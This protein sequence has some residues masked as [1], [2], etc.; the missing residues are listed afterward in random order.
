MGYTS[1][2]SEH[3][4]KTLDTGN[5]FSA[6]TA[7]LATTLNTL[8]TIEPVKMKV[9][10]FPK[11]TGV[12]GTKFI[13]WKNS[14]NG[15]LQSHQLAP[16]IHTDESS[17][18]SLFTAA[19]KVEKSMEHTAMM[20]VD[21]TGTT[22]SDHIAR[23]M[24]RQCTLVYGAIEQAVRG[25]PGA[26]VADSVRHQSTLKPK[27]FISGNAHYLY[28]SLLE[29][30]ESRS[31]AGLAT[32][33]SS[34]LDCS[35]QEH[36]SPSVIRTYYE[37]LDYVIRVNGGITGTDMSGNIV[38]LSG[39]PDT[40]KLIGL[41]KA[42]PP[43]LTTVKQLICSDT[44]ATYESALRTL[45]TAF[46]N[47]ITGT[48]HTIYG[49][50]VNAAR[51]STKPVYRSD[52]T[53]TGTRTQP[54][55][56]TGPGG[57][58]T[59][60]PDGHHTNRECRSRQN[61]HGS[62]HKPSTGTSGS[63]A[64]G[65]FPDSNDDDG[66][67]SNPES[68]IE[69]SGGDTDL[70]HCIIDTSAHKC[71]STRTT[72][73]TTTD[74]Q[75]PIDTTLFYFD[76]CCSTHI[77]GEQSIL[78]NV[79]SIGDTYM[80]CAN[81]KAFKVNVAGSFALTPQVHLSNVRQAPPGYANLISAAR[82]CD[83][84]AVFFGDTN[85]ISVYQ[86]SQIQRH[87]DTITI[88]GSPVV[89]FNRIGDVYGIERPVTMS[90]H[91]TP[92]TGTK[93]INQPFINE[94]SHSV[95][96]V[97]PPSVTHVY[98]APSG[99]TGAGLGLFANKAFKGPKAHKLSKPSHG[100]FITAYAGRLLVVGI[101]NFST[102]ETYLIKVTD[103]CYLDGSGT[104]F[105]ATGLGRFANRPVP[106]LKA[107]A[108]FSVN[109]SALTVSLVATRT[110][111][112]GDEILVNYGRA[113]K[114]DTGTKVITPPS[115]P[116]S[117]VRNI[118]H[119]VLDASTTIE[120]KEGVTI[121]STDTNTGTIT[122]PAMTCTS[123]HVLTP[124]QLLHHQLGHCS[125]Y[126]L[127]TVNQR[128]QLGLTSADITNAI[129]GTGT[130]CVGCAAGKDRRKKVST[131]TPL[132]YKAKVAMD[133]FNADICG[134]ITVTGTAGTKVRVP[135]IK[136]FTYALLFMDE[137][138]CYA[139]VSLLKLK[140][141]ATTALVT[142]IK[143]A[144]A[145]HGTTLKV[146]HSDGGGE[147]VNQEFIDFLRSNG[148]QFTTTTADHP[149]H[150][151][152]AE[153]FNG[154]TFATSRSMQYHCGA[155][156]WLWGYAVMYAV[157][158]HNHLPLRKLGGTA[159]IERYRGITRGIKHLHTYGC[160]AL[161]HTT[162]DGKIAPRI[163][164]AI[165]LG[166]NEDKDCH[167]LLNAGTGRIIH[168]RDVKFQ[169]GEFTQMALLTGNG[170]GRCTTHCDTISDNH[171]FV[172]IGYT[173]NDTPITTD[174]TDISGTTSAHAIEVTDNVTDNV[175]DIDSDSEQKH[176]NTS[177][178]SGTTHQPDSESVFDNI[179]S[180]ELDD[181]TDTS[182]G[183]AV[184]TRPPSSRIATLAANRVDPGDFDPEIKSIQD[185]YGSVTMAITDTSADLVV[186]GSDD[187]SEYIDN[188]GT[189]SSGVN[190]GIGIRTPRNMAEAKRFG[191]HWV[192]SALK[193]YQ[194]LVDRGVFKLVPLPHGVTAIPCKP[195]FKVKLD[196]HNSVKSFKTRI[197][198]QGF[199][200][201]AGT[202]Y[203]ETYAPTV[204]GATIKLMLSI[205]AAY[206]LE[207]HQL[208]FITAFLNASLDE[209]VYVKPPV[210]FPSAGTGMVWFLNKALYGLKQAPMVWNQALD[211]Y[212]RT[213]GY[214]PTKS[215]RCI[216]VK[217][218]AT[219]KPIILTVYV[220]DTLVFF[221]KS[222]QLQWYNDK[223]KINSKF[224]IEDLGTVN[225]ILNMKVVRD[226]IARTLLL[227][228]SAYVIQKLI[229]FKL[230]DCRP[231]PSPHTDPDTLVVPP[232][233][234]PSYQSLTFLDGTGRQLYQSMVGSLMYAAV[235]TRID[236]A[237]MVNCLAKYMISPTTKHSAA[238]IRVFKYLAGTT[239]LGLLFNCK[240]SYGTGTITGSGFT[241][242]CD[243][244]WAGDTIT[245]KSTT[246]YILMHNGTPLL[247]RSGRQP[248]VAGSS[249]ES[250][251][252]A[253]SELV[254]EHQWLC[255]LLGELFGTT[256][257]PTDIPIYTDSES[258][259]NI[260]NRDGSDGRTKHIAVRFHIIREA[261]Q[262]GTT[263]LEWVPTTDQL[264]DLLT[265]AVKPVSQFVSL[266]N[267]LL[268]SDTHVGQH[269]NTT[270]GTTMTVTGT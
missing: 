73:A 62:N 143:Q 76:S 106:P 240:H 237:F 12:D 233:T 176:S 22:V 68:D 193:E 2:K 239:D 253:M 234:D 38:S 71:H 137:A 243:A 10:A 5:T 201:V 31:T 218:S 142:V 161:V 194:S 248:V 6:I 228:Q 257:T 268:H 221:H 102:D 105:L 254:R 131:S 145:L 264:A 49:G 45:D 84:G 211:T 3:E 120:C 222:D 25:G 67:D 30:F 188:G 247:W 127:S 153:T 95:V 56:G 94:S 50:T 163:F 236:I 119:L 66:Y 190:S 87:T 231:A 70:A 93:K 266:R 19:F 55:P 116:P 226:R 80:T 160:D 114:R 14:V 269:S 186:P 9:D 209:V 139:F 109:K 60:H 197:V 92:A 20:K 58:C 214:H 183:T 32:A 74:R 229:E 82:V 46:M 204:K 104:E 189:N 48:N 135:T 171:E 195:V 101:D 217:L 173:I 182:A 88:K 244:D 97:V 203:H 83:G 246:G 85:G 259:I 206:D 260:A 216:Y 40:I 256:G 69:D 29:R 78:E 177:S 205:A 238:A 34:L 155:P 192:D 89:K 150:N 258:A 219:G 63:I 158:L 44:N 133:R 36:Q 57:L 103:E 200:Q 54:S 149:Q 184:T 178:I 215:D 37:N 16:L 252:I 130:V 129:S 107:N 241:S 179:P 17:L 165:Y 144:Q 86:T 169:E 15:I 98:V 148:T 11:L 196:E 140:S 128:H 180:L 108:R 79:E 113:L 187:D 138:T 91:N 75:H 223:A 1:V 157:L 81:N 245:R 123:T 225:W 210:G 8:V 52:T 224:A 64:N 42:L 147:F 250:E 122:N 43:S 198:V 199:R 213:L 26:A 21:S 33:L 53:F 162:T 146:F 141:D 18:L 61:I 151:G 118:A 126:I 152:T 41:I 121:T 112:V 125:S 110:I 35:Y 124:A 164:K 90:N 168:S 170:T 166:H 115:L 96:S 65:I 13:E 159:P 154:Q 261:L 181:T 47:R 249:A 167:V 28:Q 132:Q 230:N 220:D 235:T 59:I 72:T 185:R 100:E 23:I 39:I 202:D 191:K 136:G 51:S 267:K 174:T 99:I 270:A 4:A 227:V 77:T 232:L 251:Y 156:H 175:I 263:V 265:K 134:P 27:A 111:A 117:K 207:I 208:D 255:N 262:A 7:S 242:Y 172:G 24:I 212:L